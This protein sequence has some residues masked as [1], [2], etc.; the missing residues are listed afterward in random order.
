M[1]GTVLNHFQQFGTHSFAVAWV[2]QPSEDPVL[3][4]GTDP[5]DL[6][7]VLHR[8]GGEDGPAF[9]SAGDLEVNAT[10]MNV[11]RNSSFG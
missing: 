10:L 7:H 11:G 8:V 2:R 5:K 9:D 1:V 6:F 3:T 4:P